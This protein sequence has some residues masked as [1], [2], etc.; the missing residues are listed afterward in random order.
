M[1]TLSI[2]VVLKLSKTT[3]PRNFVMVNKSPLLINPKKGTAMR[4]DDVI[5][6]APP[7]NIYNFLASI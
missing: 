5:L 7:I 2:L 1:K 3:P 6:C 4:A